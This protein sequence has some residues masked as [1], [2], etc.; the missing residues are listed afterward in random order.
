M[1]EVDTN[2]I[3]VNFGSLADGV[4]IATGIFPSSTSSTSST[5]TSTSFVHSFDGFK[6]L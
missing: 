4:Q 5:S 2:V 1:K 3:S 6:N